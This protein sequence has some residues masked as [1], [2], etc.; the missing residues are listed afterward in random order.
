VI[1]IKGEGLNQVSAVSV[2]MAFEPEERKANTIPVSG[3]ITL[4]V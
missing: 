2:K 1:Y 3:N 4:K